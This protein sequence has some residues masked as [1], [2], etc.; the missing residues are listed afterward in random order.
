ML[1]FAKRISLWKKTLLSVQ[2]QVVCAKT[3]NK[4]SKVSVCFIFEIKELK[5][6]ENSLF[7]K[8]FTILL[9]SII[10]VS[11]IGPIVNSY[12]TNNKNIELLGKSFT[13]IANNKH[14]EILGNGTENPLI[15]D[16]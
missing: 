12:K 7:V 16:V 8:I 2:N 10:G 4:F 14:Y 1:P 11:L 13:P 6:D 5:I 3:I 15:I 9:I